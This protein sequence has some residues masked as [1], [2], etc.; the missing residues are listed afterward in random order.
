MIL[1]T[2]CPA[3]RRLMSYACIQQKQIHNL[4]I[5]AGKRSTGCNKHWKPTTQ[6]LARAHWSLLQLLHWAKTP[7]L[8]L[9]R[10]HYQCQQQPEAKPVP[11]TATCRFLDLQITFWDLL[12][13]SYVTEGYIQ[14][15]WSNSLSEIFLCIINK[16][17][18]TDTQNIWTCMK[19]QPFANKF[20]W[21]QQAEAEPNTV[22][23][24]LRI[25]IIYPQ[26]LDILRRNNGMK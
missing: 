18:C 12:S 4:E 11:V 8:Q 2:P 21:Q 22:Q 24:I 6:P 26:I 19:Q 5:S 17:A 7:L 15:W 25:A 1:F 10:C 14:A 9:Q 13:P 20:L 16:P 23:I 3:S